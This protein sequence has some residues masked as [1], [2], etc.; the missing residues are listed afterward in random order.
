MKKIL[1]VVL[2]VLAAGLALVIL[3]GSEDTWIKDSRGVWIKH[4]NPKDKPQ[5]VIEQEELIAK[6]NTLFD[7][8]KSKGTDLSNGPCLG[9]ISDDWVLDIVHNPRTEIDDL[10]QNQCSEYREGKA[11]HFI[12][13]DTEGQII[14]VR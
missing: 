8:A 3:R 11:H 7:D 14:N 2:I 10:S 4:G 6:A 1:I 13:I 5:K 12:E 9:K